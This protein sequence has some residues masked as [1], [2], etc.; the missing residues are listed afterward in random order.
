MYNLTS[1]YIIRIERIKFTDT[2][3]IGLL[4]IENDMSNL[5]SCHT[6][7]DAVRD[8]KIE[9]KTAIPAGKYKV[10]IDKSPKFKKDMPHILDQNLKELPNF[11]GVRIHAGNTAD[12][13][14]GCILVGKWDG[15][16]SYIYD[17]RVTF[18][19]FMNIL[20]KLITPT[21]KSIDLEIINIKKDD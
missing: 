13:T 18:N 15:K 14:E 20:T 12:D 1:I 17:S 11:N 4:N 7:E 9:G 6:L 5:F 19:L 10:V 3:T 8:S 16:S 21:N 2:Y